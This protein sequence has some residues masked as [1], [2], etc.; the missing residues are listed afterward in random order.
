MNAVLLQE[1]LLA[2]LP[3]HDHTLSLLSLMKHRKL[4][5]AYKPFLLTI[6]L[7]GPLPIPNLVLNVLRLIQLKHDQLSFTWVCVTS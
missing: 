3:T 5:V 4:T 1:S 6:A 7:V 2:T